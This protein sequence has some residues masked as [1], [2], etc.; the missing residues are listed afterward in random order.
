VERIRTGPAIAADEEGK[1]RVGRG[2][3]IEAWGAPGGAA[4]PG[5]VAHLR[6]APAGS[7][8]SVDGVIVRRKLPSTR[9]PTAAR[10]RRA[11]RCR[12]AGRPLQQR[13]PWCRA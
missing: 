1:G 6:D 12:S 4:S 7:G 5:E 11:M 3:V 8:M 9:S 13:S 10:E 2:A